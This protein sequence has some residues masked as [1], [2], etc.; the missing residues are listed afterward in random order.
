MKTVF[1]TGASR[2]IG[3][4][5]ANKFMS[6]GYFVIGTALDGKV[7]FNH[8]NLKI[9]S[10]DLYDDKSIER[11][12]EE[13]KKQDRRIDIFI[14]NAGVLLDEGEENIVIDKLRKTLQVNL[15]GGIDLTQ[16]ALP[17]INDGGHIINISSSA[18][19][20]EKLYHGDYPAYKI[21][22]VG[23]NMFTSWLAYKLKGKQTVSSIHPGSVR[24]DMGSGEG[25]IDPDEAAKYIYDTAVKTNLETGQFWFKDKKFPW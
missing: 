7:D 17:L 13:L 8:K 24:T 15:I 18:G 5:L 22:K 21:S 16:R 12:V 14:N 3:K 10:L 4:A 9:V 20:L 19:S 25:D 1:I 2:G 6:E 23:L 11:C